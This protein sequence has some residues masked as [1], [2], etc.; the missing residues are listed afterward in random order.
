MI[1]FGLIGLGRQGQKFIRNINE[2]PDARILKVCSRTPEAYNNLN[3]RPKGE[4]YWEEDYRNV[5]SDSAI[6]TV[7]IAT[8]LESH[9]EIAK[10]AIQQHKDVIVEKP[11]TVSTDEAFELETMVLNSATS[12][13]VDFTQLW[14][15]GVIEIVNEFKGEQ[16]VQLT[17]IVNNPDDNLRYPLLEWLP[18]DLAINL[19]FGK[20]IPHV[21]D[22]SE[23][24]TSSIFGIELVS[25]NLRHKIFINTKAPCKSR[26]LRVESFGKKKEWKDDFTSN[27]LRNMLDFY[28]EGWD[29]GFLATNI[30]LARETVELMD[31]IL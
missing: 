21:R 20:G 28:I 1:T 14:Q 8:P 7:I 11:F 31:A 16:D 18:H 15:K 9:F 27:P 24:A 10:Y 5:I 30:V 29:K 22:I 23:G 12:F 2:I 3:P 13:L 26:E 19:S 17:S 25:D 6:D 4:H